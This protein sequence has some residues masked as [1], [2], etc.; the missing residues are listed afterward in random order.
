MALQHAAIHGEDIVDGGGIRMFW[1]E[2]VVDR[3][4]RN[5]GEMRDGDRLDQG[6]VGRGSVGFTRWQDI[7]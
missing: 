1:C 4:D 2:P 3:D 5:P 6:P 7:A